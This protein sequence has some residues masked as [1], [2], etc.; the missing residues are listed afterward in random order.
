MPEFHLRPDDFVFETERGQNR[1]EKVRRLK[2][3]L[4]HHADSGPEELPDVLADR[5]SGEV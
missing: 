3:A 4:E 5:S 1:M 2:G